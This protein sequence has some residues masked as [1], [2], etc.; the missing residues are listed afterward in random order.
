MRPPISIADVLWAQAALRPAT[1]ASKA[2]IA[3]ALGFGQRTSI[4]FASDSATAEAADEPTLSLPLE[5]EQLPAKVARDMPARQFSLSVRPV[6]HEPPA[7][8]A[9]TDPTLFQPKAGARPAPFPPLLNPGWTRSILST[10]LMRPARIG[11]LDVRSVIERIARGEAISRLPQ[12]TLSV[13]APLVHVLLD[14]GP[15][16]LPFLEDQRGLLEVLRRVVGKHAVEVAHFSGVPLR[17]GIGLPGKWRAF[18]P[19]RGSAVLVVTDLGLA[20][21]GLGSVPLPSWSQFLRGARQD[22]APVVG[23]VPYPATRWPRE[24]SKMMHL[25]HWDRATPVARAKARSSLA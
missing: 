23:L 18:R 12:Q 21:G 1:D 9:T 22:G 7:Y 5:A 3:L 15:G 19:A 17:A 13:V 20:R 2:Q 25:L 16:M 11:A 10:A 4:D 8:P 14:V 6:G 24:L